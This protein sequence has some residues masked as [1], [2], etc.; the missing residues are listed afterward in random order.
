MH[1]QRPSPRLTLAFSCL[2]HAYMHMF[3]AFY[4]VIVLD[5]ERAWGLP[6]HE[7]VGLWTVGALL[8]GLGALPAGW[9]GDRWSA[10]GMMV[11]MFVG[12]GACAMACGLAQGPAQMFVGL[13]ALGLFAS[14]YH[15]VGIAWVVR[16]ALPRGRA[17]GINGIFGSI[18]VATAG[19]VAGGLIDWHGWRAAF[20]VPGVA[21]TVTGVVLLY[22]WR[23]GVVIDR[24]VAG[25]HENTPGPEERVRA[26]AVLVLTMW[27]MALIFQSTQA[28]LPKLFSL[29]LDN[30]V[31]EGAFGVGALVAVVYSIAGLAQFAGGFLADRYPL[32]VVYVLGLALQGPALLFVAQLTGAP[33]V[34]AAVMAIFLNVGILP[35]ENLLLARYTPARHRSMAFGAKFVLAFA[36]A[37]LALQFVAKVAELT[38]EFFWLYLAAAALAAVAFSAAVLLPVA[39]PP[40]AV[41]AVARGR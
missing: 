24:S 12:M 35:S 33:L 29:R 7:V 32:K 10:P 34:L 18:G 17:L 26:F 38:G 15:P 20:I 16:S 31:G 41:P 36:S 23:I 21:S 4:F 40:I 11:I 14:I 6:Y 28:A 8:V 30:L 5:L 22:L 2:G 19:V 37:P 27:S 1:V 25:E 9:L 39:T 3:A 13:S